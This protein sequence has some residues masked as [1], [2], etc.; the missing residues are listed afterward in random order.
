MYW[1]APTRKS[2]CRIATAV[3]LLSAIAVSS[4]ASAFFVGNHRGITNDGIEALRA[5]RSKTI[6]SDWE[7][8]QLEA[9]AADA[10]LIEGG[11][12]P[13]GSRYEPRYHFD[14]H[15]DYEAIAANYRD[16]VEVLR[17]NL[18]KPSPDPWEFGKVLH[19]IQDFY[20]HS[21]YIPLYEKYKQRRKE[22]IGSIPTLEEVLLS[23]TRYPGFRKELAHLRTGYYPNKSRPADKD[24]DH[25][26]ITGPG[27]HKDT[28][29]RDYHEEARNTAVRA[30]A[31][32]LRLYLKDTAA[33][34]ECNKL[35][36]VPSH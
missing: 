21:N 34:N 13:G 24:S 26:R 35:W 20:S 10:D 22:L 6:F 23:P 17:Q 18:V 33:W 27:M 32:Y 3:A 14:N 16:L 1:D 8:N 28:W 15:V 11:W 19:A 36:G 5:T 9:G 29:Q 30:T 31:W 4:D 2:T 12:Y 7:K 25:G